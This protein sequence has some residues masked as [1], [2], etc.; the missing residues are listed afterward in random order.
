MVRVDDRPVLDLAPL[1]VVTQALN[2]TAAALAVC[3][4]RRIT[5]LQSAALDTERAVLQGT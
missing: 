1:L 4:V 2:I 3:L 5:S